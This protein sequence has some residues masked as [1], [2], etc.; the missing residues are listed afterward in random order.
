VRGDFIFRAAFFEGRSGSAG[1]ILSWFA[2]GR[3]PGNR[4]GGALLTKTIQNIALDRCT[5]G[6]PCLATVPSSFPPKRRELNH[7][8][9]IRSQTTSHAANALP[10][11]SV[12]FAAV[13]AH[14]AGIPVAVH[15]YGDE[16]ADNAI[17]AGVDSI[18]HRFDLTDTQLRK[19]K[20]K[21]IFLAGTDYPRAHLDKIGTAGGLIPEPSVLAPK[22][23]GR[24]ARAHKSAYALFS[25]RIP[26][27]TCCVGHAP[28]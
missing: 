19:M 11:G 10:Q 4:A 15:V 25:A 23:I 6:R 5:A 12:D 18:E 22:I 2:S 21:G 3:I 20:K 1:L 17:E 7:S 16:A 13:E 8:G 28:R 14:H 9:T 26:K 27:T 24:L